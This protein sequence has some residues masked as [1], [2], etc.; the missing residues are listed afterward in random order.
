MENI[1][2]NNN[3]K[4]LTIRILI[5]RSKEVVFSPCI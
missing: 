3:V 2:V 1:A 5:L 4:T